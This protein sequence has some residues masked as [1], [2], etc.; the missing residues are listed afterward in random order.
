MKAKFALLGVFCI[1]G[2]Q[3]KEAYTEALKQ[4]IANYPNTTEQTHARELLRLL[5]GGDPNASRVN[6]T[7]SIVTYEDEGEDVLHYFLIIL[8]NSK[9]AS[10]NDAKSSVYNFNSKYFANR[11]F[12]DSDL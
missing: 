6:N 4:F 2:T 12:Q 11:K 8:Y 7:S 3:G 1:G 9:E 10:L 5:Y